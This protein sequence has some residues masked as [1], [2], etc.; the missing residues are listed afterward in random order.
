ML[1]TGGQLP[2]EKSAIRIKEL[3][4]HFWVW[5]ERYY[6]KSDGTAT[7]ELDNMRQ[8][9]RPLK[10][11]YADL[12]ASSY[13]PR[14]LMAVRQKMIEKGWCRRSINKHIG[15]IKTMIRWGTEQELISG[16]IYHAI[17]AVAGLI[18]MMRLGVD[19]I[20]DFLLD[21]LLP[22]AAGTLAGHLFQSEIDHRIGRQPQGKWG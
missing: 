12:P 9:L 7:Q 19:V 1:A 18:Q 21:R 5:A 6:V 13:G 3:I 11:L 22:I 17:Q 4:A 15:R 20:G 16:S 2:I 10:E 14:A 8:A